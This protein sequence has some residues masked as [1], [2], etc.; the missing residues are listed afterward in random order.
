MQAIGRRDLAAIREQARAA[1]PHECCG[2]LLRPAG[3]VGVT[4]RACTNLQQQR[5]AVDV[6]AYPRDARTAYLIDPRQL[7]ELTGAAARAGAG[8]AGFYHSHVDCPPRFSAEDRRQ[9]LGFGRVPDYPG[10]LYLVV[11]VYGGAG[12]N[13]ARVVAQS[14]YTW[15]PAAEDFVDVPLRVVDEVAPQRPRGHHSTGREDLRMAVNVHIPIPLR[16]LTQGQA[17]VK[18]EAPTVRE[19]LAGLESAYPGL[20]AKLC[21]ENGA[22]HRYINVYVGDEDIR[23]LAGLDT[24]LDDGDR[25][26]IVP[27]I[28]GGGR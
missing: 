22:V 14:G 20:G 2:L 27:A 9:A 3:A 18:I 8:V 11:S 21:D 19:L 24:A 16:R 5:H 13:A 26:A 1:Y 17:Q 10:A 7:V 23:F 4:A 15:D 25:V 6:D 12:R 28:A